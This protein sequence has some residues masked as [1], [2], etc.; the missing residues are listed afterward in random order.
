MRP[1]VSNGH[2]YRAT[3]DPGY[4]GPQSPSWQ[5]GAGSQTVENVPSGQVWTE[6]GSTIIGP[7]PNKQQGFGRIDLEDL[8]STYPARDYVNNDII[9]DPNTIPW[10]RTYQVHDTALPVKVVLAWTDEAALANEPDTFTGTADPLHILVSDLNLTV[11]FGNNPCM[12]YIGNWTTVNDDVRGEEPVGVSCLASAPDTT[13]NAELVKFFPSV[14]GATQ[15]TVKVAATQGTN[16][17]FALVV[18]N[19]YD[20]TGTAPPAKPTNLVATGNASPAVTVTWSSVQGAT[21]YEVR[22]RSSSSPFAALVSQQTGT[23]F[24]DSSVGGSTG[25][26]YFVRAV[27]AA[28]VSAD[29]VGFA[30]TMTFADDPIVSGVTP[31]KATHITELQ[32]AVNAVRAALLLGPSSFT[33]IDSTGLVKSLYMNELRTALDQARAAVSLPNASY[34][35][36]SLTAGLTLVK[37]AHVTELR[38]GVR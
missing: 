23:T 19:G 5:V 4:S 2:Y 38:S 8:L 36:P 25:Y 24:N 33:G 7:L 32:L 10:T 18:Y 16:Q 9:A 30:T 35:D 6:W 29:S 12:R 22:R 14:N 13:N 26:A 21:G 34:T 20:L 3:N 28:G 1:I 27:N 11:E 17:S 15:F 31:I 37:S